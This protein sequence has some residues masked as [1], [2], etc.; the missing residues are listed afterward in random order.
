MKKVSPLLVYMNKFLYQMDKCR[1]T[2]GGEIPGNSALAGMTTGALF[3]HKSSLV[4]A[5][6]P[7]NP[8]SKKIQEKALSSTSQMH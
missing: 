1:E 5:S 3:K 7:N 4:R 2:D 6:T 8:I